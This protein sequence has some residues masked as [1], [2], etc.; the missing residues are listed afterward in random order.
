MTTRPS[1]S[2]VRHIVGFITTAAAGVWAFVP[3]ETHSQALPI[4]EPLLVNVR[5][6][7]KPEPKKAIGM[8]LSAGHT[9][10]IPETTIK[11]IGEKLYA[12]SFVVDRNIIR[13]DSVATAMAFDENGEV[14]F[15]NVTPELLSDIRNVISNI[16]ECPMEDPSAIVQSGQ[17]GPLQQLVEVRTERAELA[18]LKISRILDDN[19]LAKL[20]RFEE[21]FGLEKGETL[22]AQ[23]PPEVLVDRLSRISHAVKK[24][25]MFKRA[26]KEQEEES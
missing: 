2:S 23:L 6:E 11:K 3:V 21:A 13:R 18:R 24:Y 5:V 20:E 17:H 22:T 12:I 25:K 26:P 14:S 7:A 1:H 8:V 9:V 16:P 10:E 19:F 15:A 4:T